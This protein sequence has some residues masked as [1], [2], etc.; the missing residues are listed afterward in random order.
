MSNTP[1]IIGN[2]SAA[3]LA[4]FVLAVLAFAGLAAPRV[5]AQA[6]NVY[7][8]PDGGGSGVCTSNTHT[9]SWFNSSA[10]WG[11]GASQIGAGTTV[12]L[13]GT[14]GTSLM[15]NGSGASG[16]PITILFEPGAKISM[17]YCTAKGCLDISNH[18]WITV[19]GGVPCGPSV[20]KSSCNGTIESTSNGT[21]LANHQ[22]TVRAI[23]A[24]SSNNIEIRNLLIQN[25][26][27]HASV[28]D[29]TP[30]IPDP[31]GIRVDGTA[32]NV[33]I[34]DTTLHDML[35]CI[36]AVGGGIQNNFKI[37][38]NDIYNTD[39]SI[40]I[41]VVSQTDDSFDIHDNHIHDSANWDTSANMYHH[42]GI[43]A[44]QTSGGRIT[45]LN[46]YNN[47]FD[48]AWGKNNTA[49]IYNEGV[50]HTETVY[51]NVF[52]GTSGN[53]NNGAMCLT[54]G[55][56]GTLRAYNN[57]VVGGS[58]QSAA[59]VKLQGASVQYKNNVVT[60]SPALMSLPSGVVF[61][62]GGINNN[63]WGGSGSVF[64]I[65]G[66]S[67][68]FIDF[69]AWKSYLPSGSGQDSQSK[70]TTTVNLS[71]SGVPQSGS[72]IA[73]AGLNLAN[74]SIQPLLADKLG[75]SRSSSGAWDAGAYSL[76]GVS[77]APN[78]PTGL[79]AI[80]N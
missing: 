4:F 40:A 25:M 49:M 35:W 20:V 43:H 62:S 46:I 14:I 17:P 56:N 1:K 63:I 10:N 57:T 64:Y 55:S 67:C 73:G 13:C 74:L 34:H 21:N 59:L 23:Y 31:S 68:S 37:Y 15:A 76:G 38:N 60:G 48:G 18:S 5:S 65:C 45:N 33:S 9:P 70:L 71:G 29:V 69:T 27:V 72:A 66:S 44:Y 32:S 42:D 54:V 52:I 39:H 7:I 51:N 8:T 79:S 22:V 3:R 77:A 41:G 2:F 26:Y 36:T 30:S 53:L 11:T 28:S 6:S 80:I 24:D 12:H 50:A 58:Q 19:D 16:K 47:L 75:N 61:A 78:P